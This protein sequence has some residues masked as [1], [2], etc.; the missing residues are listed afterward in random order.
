MSCW[1]GV[2]SDG[3]KFVMLRPVTCWNSMF[4][5]PPPYPG[6]NAR[7]DVVDCMIERR[8]GMGSSLNETPGTRVG[9]A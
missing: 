5:V 2:A 1:Y 9:S 3:A 6:D 8:F 4:A 7:P